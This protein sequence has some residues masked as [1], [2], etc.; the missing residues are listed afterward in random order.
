MKF[1]G[2]LTPAEERW[3][4]RFMSRLIKFDSRLL[5]FADYPVFLALIRIAD[6]QLIDRF[7]P[8]KWQNP[9]RRLLDLSK[10]LDVE[11]IGTLVNSN[12]AA[13]FPLPVHLNPLQERLV[14]NAY[15][16]VEVKIYEGLL[17]I[18]MRGMTRRQLR[19]F[20]KQR[21]G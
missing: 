2:L 3:L 17:N 18:R 16:M 15:G 11:G 21:N 5:E 13:T 6:N 14:R 4:A 8:E 7:V 20:K 9:F 19:K 1:R 12:Y 10:K